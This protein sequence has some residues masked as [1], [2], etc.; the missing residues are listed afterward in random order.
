[1]KTIR[2]Y[3]S[4][5]ESRLARLFFIG[6]A[7]SV[8]PLGAQTASSAGGTTPA[9][10]TTSGATEPG[11]SASSITTPPKANTSFYNTPNTATANSSGKGSIYNPNGANPPAGTV[12]TGTLNP[13]VNAGGGSGSGRTPG[14]STPSSP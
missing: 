2:H 11:S 3:S 13:N 1:M 9:Q 4:L 12:K 8:A 10:P 5:R 6:F 14:T 7:L